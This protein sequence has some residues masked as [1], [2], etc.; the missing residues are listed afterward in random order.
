MAAGAAFCAIAIPSLIYVQLGMSLGSHVIVLEG[1]GPVGA[2]ERSW[3]LI[4][5]NRLWLIL[6]G[7]VMFLLM[8]GAVVGGLVALC[9]GLIVLVPIAR[10]ITDFGY[11]ESFLLLTR[12]PEEIEGWRI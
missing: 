1:E 7:F 10:A 8:M 3:G 12:P 9:V 2:L 4:S 6:Y 5:G 11:T